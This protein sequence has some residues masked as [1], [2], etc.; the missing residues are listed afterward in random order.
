MRFASRP[1]NPSQPASIST[2]SAAGV[3]MSV[4]APPSTSTKYRSND[5]RLSCARTEQ[6]RLVQTTKKRRKRKKP[7]KSSSQSLF[8]L[9]VSSWFE[10]RLIICFVSFVLSSDFAHL[11]VVRRDAQVVEEKGKDVRRD[12]DVLGR[13]ARAVARFRF[14]ADQDRIIAGV[15][16][17]QR[18]RIFKRMSRHDAVVVIRG[19]NQR[20]RI[21]HAF[22]YVVERR[23]CVQVLEFGRVVART[24]FGDPVPAD[25]EF[26]EAQHVHYPS[27]RYDGL[28][29]LRPLIHHHA[30][31]Q[32]AVRS[33]A[34]RQLL[35]RSVFFLDEVF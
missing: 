9:F 31:Q 15:L 24:E 5:G 12:L 29:Q 17:L 10:S 20:R 35:R 28:E 14:N 21:L 19:R 34:N 1:S 2:D 33:A 11:A 30:H 8:A 3:T 18:G 22:L 32:A 6:Q 13:V 26:M 27:L 7:D 25:G 16:L 4:A 23:V